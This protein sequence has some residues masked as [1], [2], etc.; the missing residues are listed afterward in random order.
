MNSQKWV[1]TWGN[2]PSFTERRVE[3]YTADVTLRYVVRSAFDASAVRLRFSNVCNRGKATVNKVTVAKT[4]DD[5]CSILTQTLKTVTFD[6]NEAFTMEI[7]GD[8][9]SD[10]IDFPIKKG[11][12]M[13]ISF[14]IKDVTPI[15]CGTNTSGPLSLR[16]FTDG[17][18]CC[19]E[20]FPLLSKQTDGFCRFLNTVDLLTDEK[21]RSVI[22][23]GD[24]ITSLSWPEH[25]HNAYIENG[26][27]T[28]VLRRAISGS[29]ILRQYDSLSYRHYGPTG[30]KRYFYDIDT[31][32]ADTVVIL[33]GINDIIHPDGINPL[34]PM[35]HFPTA[36]ELADGLR[37][38]IDYAH[39]CGK[40]IYLCTL[41]PIKGWRTYKDF[42]NEVRNEFNDWIRTQK[43]ADGFIDLDLAFRD[44]KDPDSMLP[45][46]DKGDHLHPSEEGCK[47]IAKT[48]YEALSK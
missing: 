11:E 3:N 41:M 44:P 17:D 32:N 28:A 48:V 18:R 25:L 13:S 6:G 14:Y 8:C 20:N 19:E 46:Y 30:I 24:S 29:R 45:V 47:L 15:D 36:R 42:R 34:R 21:C 35:S 33:H 31:S 22:A 38:Y 37:I 5:P 9:V 2:S 10:A 12:D 39:K 1:S 43:E 23:F 7:D 26:D 40:K 16:F 27:D 4:G